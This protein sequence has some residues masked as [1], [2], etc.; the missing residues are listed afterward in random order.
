M[1]YAVAPDHSRVSPRTAALKSAQYA[2]HTRDGPQ[3]MLTMVQKIVSPNRPI[4][5][6]AREHEGPTGTYSRAS[7]PPRPQGTETR[8][9]R[10]DERRCRTILHY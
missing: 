6:T 4:A 5:R 1:P 3:Q 10:E 7:I 8:S 2:C 9:C